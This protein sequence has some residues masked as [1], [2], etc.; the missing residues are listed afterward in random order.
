MWSLKQPPVTY[1]SFWSKVREVSSSMFLFYQLALMS[2]SQCTGK[3]I[4]TFTNLKYC[5]KSCI[6]MVKISQPHPGKPRGSVLWSNTASCQPWN[7]RNFLTFGN[8]TQH[9]LN[10]TPY[11]FYF[12]MLSCTIGILL[13]RKCNWGCKC[14]Q[15]TYTFHSFLFLDLLQCNSFLFHSKK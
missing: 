1:G 7:D 14:N 9:L 8:F 11:N 5:S 15:S 4:I 12:F 3:Q 13:V 2:C 6:A 10:F